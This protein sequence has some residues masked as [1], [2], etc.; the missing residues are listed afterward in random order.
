MIPAT[1]IPG[2]PLAHICPDVMP[3]DGEHGRYYVRSRS[4]VRRV[5]LV[6]LFENGFVGKCNCPNFE[7]KIQRDIDR[8]IN[9]NG[10]Q[11]CYHIK[12]AERH[13]VEMMKRALWSS[14]QKRQEP[15][16]P[17][18]TPF[19]RRPVARIEDPEFVP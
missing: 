10:N 6:D 18:R 7:F 11:F 8:G 2:A 9:P 5:Y 3:I 19:Y 4:D 1:K 16:E 15:R 14:S 12:R 13:F 17:A